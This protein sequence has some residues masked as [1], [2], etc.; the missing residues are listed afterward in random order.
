M[1]RI[2]PG[3]EAELIRYHE[4]LSRHES[5]IQTALRVYAEGMDASA[6]EA[7]AAYEAGQADPKVK[8]E[9]DA[10]LM[11]NRGFKHSAELFRESAK[12]ARSASD[13]ILNAILG[14]EDG[15]EQD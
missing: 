3:M 5:L 9:Q 7:Q 12:S 11:T 14:P 2:A 13:E 6:K 1:S 8:A 10:S 15:D 4:A